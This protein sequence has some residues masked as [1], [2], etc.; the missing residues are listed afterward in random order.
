MKVL[1]V[2]I[3]TLGHPIFYLPADTVRPAIAKLPQILR[4]SFKGVLLLID[5]LV[6]IVRRLDSLAGMVENS[7]GNIRFDAEL[8]ES[9]SPGAPQVMRREGSDTMLLESVQ[10]SGN[11]SRDE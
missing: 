7:L 6:H 2:A 10:A 9:S 5:I 1:G 8:G 11:A 3:L 4:P